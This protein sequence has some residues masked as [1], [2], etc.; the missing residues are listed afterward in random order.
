MPIARGL[1]LFTSDSRL[2][3]AT[4]VLNCLALPSGVQYQFRYES[5][6]I[7]PEIKHEFENLSPSGTKALVVFREN[8]PSNDNAP[9]MVPIR[10]VIIQHVELIA[11]FYIIRF[12][13]EGYP[14]P[15]QEYTGDKES[16]QLHCSKY[17]LQLNQIARNLPV[18]LGLTS[19]VDLK[20]TSDRAFWIDVAKRLAQHSTFAA[21]H[22]I[23]V[24]NISN[25]SGKELPMS[26]G[27]EYILTEKE[28]STI[29]LDYFAISYHEHNAT[30]KLS[31]DA[32]VIRIACGG[33]I[34]LN[35]RYDSRRVS[36]QAGQVAGATAT[37]LEIFTHDDRRG[38][39]QTRLSIPFSV[40]RSRK[41]IL[42]KIAATAVGATLVA[43]PG[44]VGAS[45]DS[46]VRITIALLG[47]LV[48]TCGAVLDQKSTKP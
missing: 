48:L 21:T 6:Y 7:S 33:N 29:T 44:I 42:I 8:A 46:I 39:P 22:F 9:F 34:M 4:D 45:V 2:L 23:R 30:L 26:S 17:L 12:R 14:I 32:D 31:S 43:M 41:A 11:D 16:I 20:A 40:K 28:Y 1:T 18:Q 19:F 47:A 10:W 13:L 5:K 36:I 15:S 38:V 25:G 27:S 24:A 35:S 3:Y 37:E